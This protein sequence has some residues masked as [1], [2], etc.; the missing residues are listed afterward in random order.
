[1]PE[2]STGRPLQVAFDATPLLGTL[3]GI[4]LWAQLLLGELAQSNQLELSAFAVSYRQEGLD[5]LVPDGV[6]HRQRTMAARPLQLSWRLVRRPVMERFVGKVDVVHGT[7]YVV[8]PTKRAAK[9]V[10][11]HDLTV[12][13]YPELATPAT[14]RTLPLIT[15]AIRGGALVHTHTEAVRAEVI[16]HFGASSEQVVA[17]APGIVPL[18]A[19]REITGLLPS[20]LDRYLLSIGTAEP[21]K[22][23][24]G[25]VR[26]FDQ[27]AAELPGMGLVLV[28]QD[29]WGVGALEAAIAGATHRNRIIRLGYLD[30]G[31]LSAVLRGATALVYPSLYEGFG[32]P[33]LQAMT[34]GV[35]VIATTNA[36]LVEVLGDAALLVEPRDSASLAH[37][38]VAVSS[39]VALRRDLEV[40]GRRRAA[41]YSWE[42]CASSFED[43]YRRAA[44]ARG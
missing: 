11:V 18:V 21:R 13:R 16:E 42:R 37:A 41:R 32:F 23:L 17:I 2:A 30:D 44:A 31:K 5:A 39:H 1:M 9:V 34:V 6:A 35:P 24:P 43:L 28:G 33:P 36:S 15:R 19:P 12:V 26:A 25:L 8:G 3:T 27:A 10:S 29:G 20:H 14:L 40:R 4:G 7:N 22:D 38:M